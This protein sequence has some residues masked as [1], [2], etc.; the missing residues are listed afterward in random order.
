MAVE[1]V[2]EAATSDFAGPWLSFVAVGDVGDVEMQFVA[3]VVAV[4]VVA[5]TLD[6]QI[7]VGLRL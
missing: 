4:V 5:K 1:S 6:F 3:A 2:V 7:E